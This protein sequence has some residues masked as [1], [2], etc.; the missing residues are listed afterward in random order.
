M[1]FGE[2]LKEKILTEWAIFYLNYNSLK[3]IIDPFKK[4]YQAKI[5]SFHLKISKKKKEFI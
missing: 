1:K 2:Y 4:L 5:G 3:K